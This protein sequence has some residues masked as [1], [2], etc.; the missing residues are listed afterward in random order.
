MK[1]IDDEFPFTIYYSYYNIYLDLYQNSL[2][3][4]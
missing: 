4:P 3:Y 2:D 1:T